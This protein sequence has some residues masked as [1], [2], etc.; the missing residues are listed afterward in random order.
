MHNAEK[1]LEEEPG[2]WGARPLKGGTLAMA[3]T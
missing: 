2:A 3:G 1:P